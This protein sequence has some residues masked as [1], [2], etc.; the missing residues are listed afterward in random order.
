MVALSKETQKGLV[1][2]FVRVGHLARTAESPEAGMA[3][4]KA[5]AMIEGVCHESVDGFDAKFHMRKSA[6]GKV[7]AAVENVKYLTLET[8]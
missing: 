8:K 5:T 7:V 1:E 2:A 6:L 3:L 4:K